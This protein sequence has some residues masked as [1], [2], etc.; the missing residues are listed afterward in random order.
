MTT[1][2]TPDLADLLP[3]WERHLRA[4]NLSPRTV[5]SYLEAAD[6]LL[7]FLRAKRRTTNALRITRDDIEAFVAD[8]IERH[9]P[10]TA[11]N[12]Y[13]S[14]RQLFKWLAEEDEVD[15]SPMDGMR[16]PKVPEQPVPILG[17]DELLRLLKVCEGRGFDQRRDSA[18]LLCFI[19]TGARLSEIAYLRVDDVDL[20]V[21][22]CE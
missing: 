2:E 17:T 6:R 7:T 22:R 5:Q 21:G 20:D 14:L 10:A 13:R 1:N 9:S 8:T 16:G 3:S 19:D 11:G 12:R 15:R 4:V 18:L